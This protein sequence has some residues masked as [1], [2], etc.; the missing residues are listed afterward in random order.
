M[1]NVISGPADEAIRQAS[2]EVHQ[3][4]RTTD[5]ILNRQI[6][7]ITCILVALIYLAA[8]IVLGIKDL[9]TRNPTADGLYIALFFAIS[10]WIMSLIQIGDP[11]SWAVALFTENLGSTKMIAPLGIGFLILL[12]VRRSNLSHK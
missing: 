8:F 2:G 9:P 3:H 4:L 1:G 7:K 10:A 5:E 12:A 11:E 6:Q